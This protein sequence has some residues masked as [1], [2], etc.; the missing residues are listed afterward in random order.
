VYNKED[1]GDLGNLKILRQ[2]FSILYSYSLYL[3]F[4]LIYYH[5]FT[6]HTTHYRP[7]LHIHKYILPFQ[8][9]KQIFMNE[10]CDIKQIE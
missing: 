6:K 3:L 8:D 2:N 1:Y 4:N 5:P 9:R 10:F 7:R